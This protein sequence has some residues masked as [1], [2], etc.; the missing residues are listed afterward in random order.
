[1]RALLYKDFTAAKGTYLLAG[2]IA[3]LISG[4]SFF[5]GYLI[6]IPLIFVFLSIMLSAI[7]F[8]LDEQAE[9][10]KFVFTSSISRETFVKSKYALSLILA[11]LSGISSLVIFSMENYN[12]GSSLIFASV[13]Y[14]LPLVFSSV[15][16]P[17]FLKYGAEK[18]RILFV[19]TY[20]LLILIANYLGDRMGKIISKIQAVGSSRPYLIALAIF[21]AANIILLVSI[22]ISNKLIA[23][24]DY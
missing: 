4:Y 1:M 12:L 20:F 23:N 18:G 11:L 9:I 2:I 3:L 13:I 14:S 22:K 8:G 21:L 16:V 19:A 15:Q 17:F 7:S 10:H 24:K 6:L 5:K